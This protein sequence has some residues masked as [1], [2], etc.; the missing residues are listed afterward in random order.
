MLEV[1]R[2]LEI[3]VYTAYYGAPE[4]FNR[5]VFGPALGNCRCLVFSDDPSLEVPDQV[6][7]VHDPLRGLDPNRASRRAKLAPEDYLPDTDWSIYID[8]NARLA[9]A[10]ERLVKRCLAMQSD[11]WFFATR[12]PERDCI[13]D[14][15]VACIDLQR[16]DPR[17]IESQ[18]AHYR[19]LGMPENW[20]LLHGGCLIRRHRAIGSREFGR[21]WYEHV[22]AYSRR[23]QLSFPFLAFHLG[24]S[25]MYLEKSEEM[26][27]FHWPEYAGTQRR[28]V[29]VKRGS[30]WTRNIKPIINRARGKS[31]PT[32]S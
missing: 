25:V 32:S 12:H 15:A 24:L 19:S 9:E 3:V 16:D 5:N 30:F 17:R 11:G 6:T 31:P 8:N 7:V 23:D 13:F 28:D 14:E 26:P 29:L 2:I 1:D 27:V 20:G 10:P 21:S 18:I 4:P 22:L